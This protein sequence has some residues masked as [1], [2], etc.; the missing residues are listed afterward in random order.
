VL[1]LL[2][3]SV[4]ARAFQAKGPIPIVVPIKF[5]YGD[6]VIS[7]SIDGKAPQDFGLTMTTRHSIV[8]DNE[9]AG[10]AKQLSVSGKSLGL[11]NLE[12]PGANVHPVLNLLGLTVLN[13]MAIGVDYAKNEIT[14]WPGGRIGAEVAKAWVQKAAKWGTGSSVWSIPILR[15]AD[16]APVI[17]LSIGGKKPLVLLRIGQQG[18]SFARGEEPQS[19]VPVEYG[20]GGNHALLT[21]VGIG[22]TT[23]PWILYFRGVSYD[24][25]KEIDP[26]IAGTFTTENLLARRVILDLAANVMYSEQLPEDEQ[27]SMFLSEWFQMP[28][29]VQGT[30]MSLREMPGTHFYPQLASIYESEVLEIMGQ[31]AEQLISAARNCNEEHLTYL[32]LLFERVWRGYKVKI[33]KP[34]GEVMEATFS[35]PK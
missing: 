25:R 14:F 9:S 22:P 5:F 13:T 20:P 34:N 3:A 10:A 1:T 6:P 15:K 2:I 32:K 23:L 30:K 8:V 26:S 29:D 12:A 33:K 24:P 28:I 7:I 31:T 11:A 4:A 35:P 16:V 19:G 27:I 18:T 21:K 17:P